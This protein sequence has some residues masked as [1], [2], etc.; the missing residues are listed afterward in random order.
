MATAEHVVHAVAVNGPQRV[1]QHVAVLTQV[2]MVP[3]QAAH[4]RINVPKV[5]IQPAGRH[6]VQMLI[7]DAMR[8][9]LVLR[10][11]V[12]NHVRPGPV[13]PV[14]MRHQIATLP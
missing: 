12:Q 5:R 14:P 2:A 7:M 1:L 9:Q 3:V 6:L 8:I 13:L 11:H 4:A 10:R